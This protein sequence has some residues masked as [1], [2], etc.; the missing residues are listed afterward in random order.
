MTYRLMRAL[1]L[2][3]S[4]GY[5]CVTDVHATEQQE[6][7]VWTRTMETRSLSGVVLL[8]DCGGMRGVTVEE[9]SPDRKQLRSRVTT[10]ANGSFE[11][12]KAQKDGLR[13]MKVHA[14]GFNT[15]MVTV[16]VTR[17]ASDALLVIPLR[18]AG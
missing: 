18:T 4:L 15:I 11:L 9:W 2:L 12:P 17:Q 14:A 7:E 13:Y 6:V 8:N 16:K 3:V 1:L 10:S 5:P